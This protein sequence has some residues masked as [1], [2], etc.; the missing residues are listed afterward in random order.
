ML[1]FF[2]FD[3]LEYS[4]AVWCSAAETYLKILDG[5]VSG[6]R[7][8]TGGVFERDIA[9]CRSVAVLCMLHKM[10]VEPDALSLWCSTLPVCASAGYTRCFSRTSVHLWTS[11]LMNRRT[12]ILLLTPSQKYF[13]LRWRLCSPFMWRLVTKPRITSH[14]RDRILATFPSIAL[15]YM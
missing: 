2:F 6:A 13:S 14:I 7:L 1:S 3:V 8:S 12:Y 11:S 5:V 15:P 4:S 9:H 10:Q